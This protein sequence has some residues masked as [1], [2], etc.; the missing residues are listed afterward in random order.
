M[1]TQK[2]YLLGMLILKQRPNEEQLVKLTSE[3]QKIADTHNISGPNRELFIKTM[4][5]PVDPARR[6][7]AVSYNAATISHLG[8]QQLEQPVIEAEKVQ[9]QTFQNIIAEGFKINNPGNSPKLPIATSDS[10]LTKVINTN[11]SLRKAEIRE[12]SDILRA[13]AKFM[14]QDKISP[15]EAI[16][17]EFNR[18]ILAAETHESSPYM[19]SSKNIITDLLKNNPKLNAYQ[20]TDMS[21]ILNDMSLKLE[22][23]TSSPKEALCKTLTLRHIEWTDNAFNLR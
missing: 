6:P 1:E 21:D 4:T 13:T 15:Q 17:K 23:P 5:T 10:I 16:I 18:R 2:P 12:I 8:K 19:S 20:I 11:P 22:S 14:N 3:V 7:R 9:E